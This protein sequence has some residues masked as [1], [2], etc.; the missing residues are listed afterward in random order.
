MKKLLVLMLVLGM[1]SWAS[2]TVTFEFRDSTGT[3]VISGI[4]VAVGDFT[5]FVKGLVGDLPW[6]YG[7]YSSDQTPGGGLLDMTAATV[8]P[9]AGDLGKIFGNYIASY[10]GV[11]VAS[12]DIDSGTMPNPAD[13]DWFRMDFSLTE[14]AANGNTVQVD[15]L[16][17]GSGYALV[18]SHTLDVVPEPMTIAL[19]GLGGLF[20][21]R[22]R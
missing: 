8:Y 11:D 5:F 2:A 9:A 21:R 13:G 4:D 10:D 6:N 16:D 15:I 7:V 19:L 3:S 1:V 14:S 12:G 20:L 17:Y 22:R 18:S